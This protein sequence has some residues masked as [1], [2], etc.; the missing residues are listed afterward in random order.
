MKIHKK[1]IFVIT[2][3][4]LFSTLSLNTLANSLKNKKIYSQGNQQNFENLPQYFSWKDTRFAFL[5]V[6]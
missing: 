4:I 1:Y 6:K 2:V 5:G 3:I